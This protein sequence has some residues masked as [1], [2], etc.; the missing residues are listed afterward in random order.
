MLVRAASIF[1]FLGNHS[2]DLFL[3]DPA[4][5]SEVISEVCDEWSRF[6]DTNNFIG[7]EFNAN[8][9]EMGTRKGPF[10]A[11]FQNQWN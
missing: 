10:W 8:P 4:V 11:E 6:N 2:K 7:R 1:S 3:F 9:G 5:E